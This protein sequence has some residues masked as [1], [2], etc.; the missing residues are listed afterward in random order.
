MESKEAPATLE[1][2]T[3]SRVSR[4]TVVYVPS[5]ADPVSL[6][7]HVERSVVNAFVG[8]LAAFAV[9]LLLFAIGGYSR[10]ALLEE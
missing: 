7:F 8:T 5:A 10:I 4:E 3:N 6:S 9:L 1:F 2:G